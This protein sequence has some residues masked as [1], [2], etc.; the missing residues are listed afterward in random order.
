MSS[1]L[2]YFILVL[3]IGGIYSGYSSKGFTEKGNWGE[4]LMVSFFGA[5][6]IQLAFIFIVTRFYR[7]DKIGH[8]L[9]SNSFSAEYSV[10]YRFPR[11]DSVHYST[12]K[13]YVSGDEGGCPIY[14]NSIGIGGKDIELWWEEC[15]YDLNEWTETSMIDSTFIEVMILKDKSV[16]YR[17]S[18]IGEV[19]DSKLDSYSRDNE[20]NCPLKVHFIGTDENFIELSG[21]DCFQ[22]INVWVE[23]TM[24]DYLP[25]EIMILDDKI[26]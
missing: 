3:L 6:I 18:K 21:D 5:F 13:I 11:N 10:K 23:T 8:L 9:A 15:F 26:E 24:I 20:D 22:K 16:K 17:Y 2:L 19:F 4:I 12:A 1:D 25:I 7:V 14:V